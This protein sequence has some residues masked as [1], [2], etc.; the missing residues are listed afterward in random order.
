MLREDAVSKTATRASPNC[1]RAP[2]LSRLG[3]LRRP[4]VEGEFGSDSRRL[5]AD[6]AVLDQPGAS[7][8]SA[9]SLSSNS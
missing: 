6:R 3:E 9:S 5:R 1:D 7:G 2:A 4:Q 8:T